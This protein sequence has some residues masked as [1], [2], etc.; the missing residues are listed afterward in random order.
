MSGAYSPEQ[1]FSDLERV[2]GGE[3]DADLASLVIAHSEGLPSWME[4]HGALWQ[5]P[6]AGTLQ[7]S[8]TN[9]FF[10]GGGKA[11]LNSYYRTAEELGIVTAYEAVV[12]DISF[13]ERR[14]DGVTVFANGGNSVLKPRAVVVAAGGYEANR[15]WLRSLWGEAATNFRIRGA[16]SNDGLVLR[17]LLDGGA[18]A[19]GPEAGFHA[20]AVDARA[21]LYDGGIVTRV[22]AIPFGVAINSQGDRFYDEGEDLWPFR[23]AVW[24]RLIAAQPEQRAYVIFDSK[25]RHRFI[26][27]LWPPIEATTLEGLLHQLDVAPD[28]SLATIERFNAAVCDGQYDPTTLD[29]CCARTHPPKSHWALRIDAPPYYAYPLRPGITFTYRGVRVDLDGRVV[30][31][32][33]RSFTNLFAAGEIMAGN[34]LRDGY[35]AGIGMTIGTVIGRLAGT[36]ASDHAA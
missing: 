2:N 13:I 19:V 4:Q 10:L 21:P 9:R 17:N 22:D 24:G 18:E 36:K 33:G 5:P 34:I 14:V 3:F 11:L 23:Y 16:R 25:V 8:R 27:S 7:L 31:R 30:S 35:L 1:F 6:L 20:T 12:R 29:A 32:G 28:R 15:A 26:P